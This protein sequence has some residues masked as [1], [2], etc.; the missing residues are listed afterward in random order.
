M[1][2]DGRVIECGGPN[3]S[4]ASGLN[5]PPGLVVMQVH[6]RY[7]PNTELAGSLTADICQACRI[8]IRRGS[9]NPRRLPSARRH[10]INVPGD[11]ITRQ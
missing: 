9:T 3:R 10:R 8:P 6:G 4:N 5:D 11:D 1:T 2:A 7:N